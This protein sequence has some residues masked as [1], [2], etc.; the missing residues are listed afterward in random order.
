MY[1]GIKTYIVSGKDLLDE[2]YMNGISS[3]YDRIKQLAKD[4]ANTLIAK[5]ES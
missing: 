4:I 3:S 5:A 1:M 2:Y